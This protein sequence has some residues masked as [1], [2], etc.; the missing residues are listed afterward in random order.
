MHV[1]PG[2]QFKKRANQVQI[3]RREESYLEIDCI[4]AMGTRLVQVGQSLSHVVVPNSAVEILKKSFAGP[5]KRK[6][7]DH[8]LQKQQF[9]RRSKI[10]WGHRNVRYELSFGT[11]KRRER[12]NILRVTAR[13]FRRKKKKKKKSTEIFERKSRKRQRLPNSRSW[14]SMR[15]LCGN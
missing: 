7:Y 15:C 6:R 10:N 8:Q 12:T 5:R 2:H 14:L 4:A 1:I 3:T 11:V 9:S 13:Q